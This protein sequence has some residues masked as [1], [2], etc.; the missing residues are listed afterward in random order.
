M[1]KSLQRIA[2][3][4]SGVLLLTGL[5]VTH[6]QP[7]MA[8]ESCA[9]E[10]GLEVPTVEEA[11]SERV[12]LTIHGLRG[13]K[14]SFDG[15]D[16][17]LEDVDGAVVK[18]FSYE[19]TNDRW[20]T[21]SDTAHRLA[22]TIVCYSA[23]YNGKDVLL[24]THSMGGLLAREALDWAA[25]G[26]FVKD[27][28]KYV[29]TIAPPHQGSQLA[30]IEA[31]FWLSTCTAPFPGMFVF[32]VEDACQQIEEGRAVNGLSV[33]SEQ[34]AALPEFPEGVTVKTI[35][36]DAT[37]RVC[38]PWGCSPGVDQNG[39]LVVSVDSAT[40]EYTETGNGDGKTVFECDTAIPIA[41]ITDAWCEHS[42]MLQAEQ[43]QQEVKASIEA[44]IAS[45]QVE[46]TNLHG[47]ELPL[48]DEWELSYMTLHAPSERP[49]STVVNT[50]LCEEPEVND[51]CPGGFTVVDVA[52][53]NQDSSWRY[54]EGEECPWYSLRDGQWHTP[55]KTVEELTIGGRPATHR[56]HWQ[57]DSDG[58]GNAT[59]PQS[60]EAAQDIMHS[61]EIGDIVVVDQDFESDEP[62]AGLEDLLAGASVS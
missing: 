2:V 9:T 30:N 59:P 8:Q 37:W 6:P 52:A 5:V 18:T 50:E 34:L 42:N 7:A 61:W 11:E 39:D 44:Y 4:L 20:V 33:D 43:V 46:M 12:A 58:N 51:Y 23:L 31:D 27:V 25:D 10:L 60:A 24:V 38:A 47:L 62:L 45:Q 3:G 16:G 28:A 53:Y 56:T 13:N 36:G 17:E 41:T 14:A 26:V 19:S 48:G 49:Y 15:M 57:C 22:E 40:A 1:K 21:D 32:F 29:I 55:P 54:G 35:A